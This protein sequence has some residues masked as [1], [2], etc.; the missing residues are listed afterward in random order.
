MLAQYWLDDNCAG[1]NDCGG[2]DL[3]PE[4]SPDGDVD[5]ADLA[6]FAHHWLDTGCN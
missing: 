6:V 2:A 1:S 5:I 4:D 3:Q